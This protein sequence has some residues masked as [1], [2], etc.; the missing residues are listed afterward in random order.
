MTDGKRTEKKRVRNVIY[1]ICG[2]GM[3]CA[4]SLMVVPFYFPA[5]TWWV[6]TAALTF[7]SVSWLVKGGSFK[8]LED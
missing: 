8:F 6:E 7:F 4:M 3:L 5:K 2:I 1:R